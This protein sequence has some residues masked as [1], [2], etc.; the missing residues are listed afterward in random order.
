MSYYRLSFKL[1]SKVAVTGNEVNGE[2][3]ISIA[4]VDLL[5]LRMTLGQL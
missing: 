1:V 4:V 5:C 2:W 3:D